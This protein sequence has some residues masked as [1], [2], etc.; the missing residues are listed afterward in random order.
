MKPKPRRTPRPRTICPEKR[1]EYNLKQREKRAARTPEKKEE[2]RRKRRAWLTS[3]SPEAKEEIRRS[4]RLKYSL[5]TPEQR[6]ARRERDKR[7]YTARVAKHLEELCEGIP[8][9]EREQFICKKKHERYMKT[10]KAA[11]NKRIGNETILNQII[12]TKVDISVQQLAAELGVWA[13]TLIRYI[14]GASPLKG[15]RQV[16]VFN[17]LLAHG[18]DAEDI[19]LLMGMPPEIERIDIEKLSRVLPGYEPRPLTPTDILEI[20]ECKGMVHKHLNSLPAAQRDIIEKRFFEEITL[21]DIGKINGTCGE[22]VRQLEVLALR[23]LRHPSR[24][25]QLRELID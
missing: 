5:L 6:A 24:S 22:Y 13:G 20:C 25:R 15:K 16:A 3:L 8:P 1:E 4:V 10:S 18:A 17:I 2:D 21:R 11:L 19:L 12:R 23:K 9:E 14:Q 7:R